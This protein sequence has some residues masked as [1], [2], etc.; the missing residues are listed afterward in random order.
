VTKIEISERECKEKQLPNIFSSGT[1]R[2][3][4]SERRHES[5]G[6]HQIL[7]KSVYLRILGTR[8]NPKDWRGKNLELVVRNV[9]QD[10]KMHKVRE[11]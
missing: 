11:N 9:Q 8:F 4:K 1:A 2:E 10:C 3:R 6:I 7:A 5:G